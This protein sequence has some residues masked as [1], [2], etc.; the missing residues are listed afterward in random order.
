MRIGTRASALALAQAE[1][2]AGM[3]G[4]AEIVPIVTRGDRG[5][6]GEDKSRWVGELEAALARGEVDVAVHSAKDVPG[7]LV[8]GLELLGSPEREAPED[9][10]IGVASLE[11]L[12]EHGCVGTSSVRRAAQLL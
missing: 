6:D 7:E 4:G 12:P 8:E 2:V 11:A 10:L 9:A 5:A 3:L 1:L